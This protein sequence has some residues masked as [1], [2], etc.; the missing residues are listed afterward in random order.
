MKSLSSSLICSWFNAFEPLLPPWPWW[1]FSLSLSAYLRE[2]RV[3]FA[4]LIP[5]Q[6][7]VSITILTFSLAMNESRRTIVS[8]LWRKGTCWPWVAWPFC[9]SRA[10]THSLRPSSDWLISAPSAYLSLL[11]LMQSWALSLPAKSTSNNL[12]HCLTPCSWILICVIAWLLLDVSL[13]LVAWVVRIWFPYFIK[14][15]IWSS[16]S[17]NYSLRPAI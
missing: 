5:G 17:T 7:Q 8:L 3:W 14:S 15:R 1:A 13:A 16:L 9:E 2:L 11:L 12:P 6:M 4:E 10:L